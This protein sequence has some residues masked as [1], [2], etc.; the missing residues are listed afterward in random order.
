ME[1]KALSPQVIAERFGLPA[2]EII[3]L[4][5]RHT[6]AVQRWLSTRAPG[7]V[8]FQGR[9]ITVGSTGLNVPLVNLALGGYFDGAEEETIERETETV[10][11]FF[12]ERGVPWSWWLGPQTDPPDLYTRVE[13]YGLVP[14]DR[15]LPALAARLPV[16]IPPLDPDIHV[17][18]ARDIADLEATSTI[19]RIAFRF[20]PDTAL[21]YFEACADDWLNHTQLYLARIGDGPP[22]AIGALIIGLGYPGVYVMATL[23]D[24]QRQGLGRAIMTCLMQDANAT[25]C[26]LAFLTASPYGYPLYRQYGFEHIFDYRI[27]SQRTTAGT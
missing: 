6:M 3:R 19:R 9:G 7:A 14:R 15:L 20:P 26:D 5:D 2:A 1:P 27:Y 21:D 11:S 24:W 12:E 4:G 23:P 25:G 17:W 13:R 22:A 16:P 10:V 18:R 8:T